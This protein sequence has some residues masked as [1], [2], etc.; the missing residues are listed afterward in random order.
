MTPGMGTN[1]DGSGG[2]NEIFVTNATALA[3]HGYP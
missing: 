2:K 3:T 1:G